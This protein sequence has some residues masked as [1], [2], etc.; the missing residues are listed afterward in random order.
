ME[1][2]ELNPARWEAV[3]ATFLE[4]ADLP[5]EESELAL[6]AISRRDPELAED[7]R[8]MLAS[9]R[10]AGGGFD[11][12]SLEAVAADVAAERQAAEAMDAA[13]PLEFDGYRLVR[14]IGTGSSGAVYEAEERWP[15]RRVAIKL[16]R[17]GRTSEV[18]RHRF[19]REAEILAKFSDDRIMRVFRSGVLPM[20]DGRPYIVLEYVE[21]KRLLESDV[22]STGVRERLRLMADVCDAVQ[23]AHAHGVIHRDLKPANI[24][25]TAEGR[26]KVLDF[27]IARLIGETG[28]HAAATLHGEVLGTAAYMSPEQAGGIGA[29]GRLEEVDTQTD[30]YALGAIAYHLLSGRAPIDASGRPLMELLACVQRGEIGPLSSVAPGTRGD[31]EAVVMRALAK[32]REHRFQSMSELRAAR[33]AADLT[34]VTAAVSGPAQAAGELTDE[35]AQRCYALA[36]AVTTADLVGAA[37][38]AHTLA[39]EYAKVR[40]QYGSAIGSYQAVAHMLAEGLALI[41][42]SVSV[43]RHAA[44]AVDEL[45]AEVA[46]EAARV[47]KIYCAR[48]ALAV[49]EMSIQVHGG[50]G[51]TWECLAH[52]YLRRV[53][54]A[55]EAW[56]VKLEELTIGLS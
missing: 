49:C 30:V 20:P 18:A 53:L 37:R 33:E 31:I 38:G 39:T 41:E 48:A 40:E 12:R 13:P 54:A 10:E 47:A 16:L 6:L 52:V 11:P 23:K 56:P 3:Q 5:P 36:L 15:R 17:A 43:L 27:G 50:I 28:Q 45:P 21:G 19:K 22:A 26:P 25:V 9:D 2:H 55:T 29:D 1:R 8:R 24:I 34:R 46:V 7:V 35:Q 4:L 44:W 42:G 51:N 14:L 32:P